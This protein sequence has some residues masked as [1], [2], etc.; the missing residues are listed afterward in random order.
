MH[1]C[2]LKVWTK[3]C[4]KAWHDVLHFVEVKSLFLVPCQPW[5]SNWK[6]ETFG[7]AT[8]MSVVR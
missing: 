1:V 5:C 2:V 7:L 3:M 8:A 4:E 6:G